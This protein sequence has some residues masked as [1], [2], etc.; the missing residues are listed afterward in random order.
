MSSVE[1]ILLLTA[2]LSATLSGAAGLGGGTILI[3]VMFAVGLP[4]T[5]AV[6]LFAAVQ[7]VSNLSRTLVYRSAVYWGG[8]FW[9][10]VAL[11]LTTLLLL[12]W[13]GR[14]DAHLLSLLLAALVFLSLLPMRLPWPWM[15]ARVSVT[16]A[17]ILNGAVGLFVGATGLVVG[18]L[19]LRPDWS[20]Q[21][22]IATL[23]LTQVLGHALRVLILGLSGF[24][25]LEDAALLLSLC[26][27][28]IAGT[29]VG[30]R[31]NRHIN[32]ALF[33]ILFRTILFVLSVK[34]GFDGFEGLGWI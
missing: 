3:A 28:V 2:F 25:V 27:A 16:V 19:F 5:Q 8:L 31:L 29:G 7:L 12:P 11:L 9:F 34:L 1:I 6:A 33:A 20:R 32:E 24:S 23:A 18:R 21:T 14:L 17:G 26:A 15:P 4:P 22:T 10:C 30:K 13:L